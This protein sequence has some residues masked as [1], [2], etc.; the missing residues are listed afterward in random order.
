MPRKKKSE[1]P[2]KEETPKPTP[3]AATPSNHFGFNYLDHV[4]SITEKVMATT[5]TLSA[6][7]K[8]KPTQF[9]TFADVRKELIPL[10]DLPLQFLCDNPG[11]PQGAL[12]E[13]IGAEGTGKTTLLHTIE[14]QALMAGCPV[15]H[16]ECE[17]KPMR[18]EHVARILSSDPAVGKHLLKGIHYDTARSVEESYNKLIDWIKIMRGK[19]T[20]GRKDSAFELP[21]HV[22]LVAVIDPWGKLMSKEEAEGFYDYG[23]GG[24]GKEKELLELSNLGHSKAAHRWVR[25]LPSILGEMNVTLILSQHQNVKID[26]SGHGGAMA[27]DAGALYND[28]KIGGKAFGQLDSM[29]II[30]VRKGLVKDSAGNPVGKTIRARMHKNSYGAESRVIEYD[31]INDKYKDTDTYLD[32]VLRFDRFTAEW[33]AENGGLDMSIRLRRVNC[34]ELGLTGSTY[35]E[36]YAA[37]VAD[38]DVMRSVAKNLRIQGFGDTMEEIEAAIAAELVAESQ[39]EETPDAEEEA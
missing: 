12:I 29:Q 6:R 25:R 14:A 8:N 23:K 5:M 20:G 13:I 10:N 27:G 37:L 36:F 24:A 15:Y 38:K 7:R 3:K 1:T 39:T 22:P 33:L 16:Q 9:R 4:E 18:K 17:N 31:L 30:L 32:R 34:E 35:S 21:M 28:T 26:M 2:A 19:E 11:I